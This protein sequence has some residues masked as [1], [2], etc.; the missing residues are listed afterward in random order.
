MRWLQLIFLS[1][2]N[3][4]QGSDDDLYDEFEVAHAQPK[5]VVESLRAPPHLASELS[6]AKHFSI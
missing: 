3:Q 6:I 4:N 1:Y 5:K 2:R